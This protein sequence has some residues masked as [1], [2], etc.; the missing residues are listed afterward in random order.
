MRVI[1]SPVH[2]QTD[3]AHGWAGLEHG[4]EGNKMAESERRAVV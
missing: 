3:G 1:A 4:K 2:N